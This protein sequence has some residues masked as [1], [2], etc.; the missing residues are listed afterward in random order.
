MKPLFDLSGKVAVVT[1]GAKGIGAAIAETL[2]AQG[3]VVQILDVDEAAGRAVVEQLGGRAQF[4]T[5]DV[6][7]YEQVGQVMDRLVAEQGGLDLLINNAGISHIGNV[8]STSPEDMDRLYAVNVKGVYNCL[9]FGV[10]HLQR[11]GGG[12]IVNIASVASTV[13][14]ADRFAYS[15]TKGAVLTMTLSVAKDFLPDKIRCNAVAPARV[16]TPFVDGYLQQHYAGRESEMYDRL[17]AT[18]PIGR[19]GRPEE[20][21]H[22]VLYLCSDEASFITGSVYPIDGG[23]LSLNT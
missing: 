1:G 11:S 21:A 3:A 19:M 15:A 8:V 18:Q 13:G 7:Q 2:A 14:I 6:S 23:F 16:H 12:A 10:P 4:H 22:L 17:A 5:C 20:V 9:H